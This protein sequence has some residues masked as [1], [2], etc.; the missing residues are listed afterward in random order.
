MKI[1]KYY[2]YIQYLWLDQTCHAWQGKLTCT[3]L[4]IYLLIKYIV[5]MVY[6][7]VM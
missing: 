6:I 3:L 4:N 5:F 1:I 2:K 7:T